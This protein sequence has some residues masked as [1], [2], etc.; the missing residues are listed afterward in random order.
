MPC[1]GIYPIKGSFVE[2]IEAQADPA[3]P[4][5]CWTCGKSDPKPTFW[6][7]EWDTPI[8]RECIPEFLTTDEG[9]IVLNHGHMVYIPETPA[10]T[11][12]HSETGENP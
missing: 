11:V 1:G 9:R 3:H 2:P 4:M 7:E 6:C 8:H 10:R 12:Q 5:V